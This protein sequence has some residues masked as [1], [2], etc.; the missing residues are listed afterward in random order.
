MYS[1]RFTD[2]RS[3]SSQHQVS[4][5]YVSHLTGNGSEMLA[6]TLHKET[7]ISSTM[8]SQQEWKAQGREAIYL[9][10]SEQNRRETA[11]SHSQKDL[12]GTLQ[13]HE[14]PRQSRFGDEMQE[15]VRERA[16]ARGPSGRWRPGPLNYSFKKKKKKIGW[17]ATQSRLFLKIPGINANKAKYFYF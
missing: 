8:F 3:L 1:S 17:K 9:W 4:V 16:Q 7:H 6:P 2:P 11:L 13:I 14:G 10:D 12:F 15:G 5:L